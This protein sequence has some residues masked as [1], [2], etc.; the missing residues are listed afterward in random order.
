MKAAYLFWI[1]FSEAVGGLSGY[2][3]REGMKIYAESAVKP[4]LTPPALAF[5][6]VWTVLYALMGISAARVYKAS[7]SPDRTKGLRMFMLQLAVNFAWCF[8]F[9]TFREYMMSF[10]VLAALVLFTAMMTVYFWRVDALSG[11]LQMP[12]IVW[13]IFAGYL[14]LGVWYLN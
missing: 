10:A 9:F 8:V 2:L 1:A 14:N 5:P 13:L 3:T 6:V 11:Y 7:A 4:F 12:Y